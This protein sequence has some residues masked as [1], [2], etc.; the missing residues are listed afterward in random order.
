MSLP[1][2]AVT[3]YVADLLGCEL[4]DKGKY[5][6]AKV[7]Y[8]TALEERRSPLG[9]EYKDTLATL[10]S[11]GALLS[12]IKDYKGALDYYQQTLRVQ[13][14]VLGKTHPDTLTT[15]EGMTMVYKAGLKDFTK[16]CAKHLVRLLT[17][18]RTKLVITTWKGSRASYQKEMPL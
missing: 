6:E 14:K 12:D 15:I 7:F 18:A 9:D 17:K 4:Q 16:R 11:I 2:K 8:L 13:E 10:I 3:Y 1:D 5:E